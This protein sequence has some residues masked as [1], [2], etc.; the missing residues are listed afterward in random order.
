MIYTV[1]G[2]VKPGELV[3]IMGASGA[4]KSTMLNTLTYRN[5]DGLEVYAPVTKCLR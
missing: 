5:M 2:Y 1:S 4:G 3:A